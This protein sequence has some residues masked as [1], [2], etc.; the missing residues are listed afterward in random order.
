VQFRDRFERQDRVIRSGV[1]REG[2]DDGGV[3][4]VNRS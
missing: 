3:H 4:A 2:V 1:A